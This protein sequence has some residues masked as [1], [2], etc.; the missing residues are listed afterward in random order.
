L[1]EAQD[2]VD[3]APTRVLQAVSKEHA[4]AAKAKLEAAGATVEVKPGTA[5]PPAGV[6][7]PAEEQTEFD[8]ILV[9]GGENKIEVIKVVRQ[10]TNLSLRK[11]QD[12]VDSAPTLVLQA[13]SKEHAAAAKAKLEEVGA[14]VEVK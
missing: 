13:V 6:A 1:K 10:L 8:V 11:A 12:L 9:A 3:S 14:T 4:A 7:I 5:P 2:L